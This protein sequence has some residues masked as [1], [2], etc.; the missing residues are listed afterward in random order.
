MAPD[1]NSFQEHKVNAKNRNEFKNLLGQVRQR[2]ELEKKREYFIF[3]NTKFK[4]KHYGCTK[5]NMDV[6][7]AI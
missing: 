6:L 5:S 7:K 4:E 2:K 1:R 3:N